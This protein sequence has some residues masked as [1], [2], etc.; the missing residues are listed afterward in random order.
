MA[1]LIVKSRATKAELTCYYQFFRTSKCIGRVLAASMSGIADGR[2]QAY[3]EDM[4]ELV[5][6]GK[7]KHR[8]R[9]FD[10]VL[11]DVILCCSCTVVVLERGFMGL[12]LSSQH[13]LVAP[14]TT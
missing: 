3:L 2:L 9:L 1:M 8:Q 6:T 14:C 4:P 10:T 13:F 5:E 7:G 12:E 11:V